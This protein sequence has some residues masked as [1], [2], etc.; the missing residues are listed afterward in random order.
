LIVSSKNIA[1][2]VQSTSVISLLDA[3]EG[4]IIITNILELFFKQNLQIIGEFYTS[5]QCFCQEHYWG[6]LHCNVNPW[7]CGVNFVRMTHGKKYLL[8]Y[9]L[10]KIVS[11]NTF[12][13]IFKTQSHLPSV[14]YV[15]EDIN[16]RI[17]T[18]YF[19]QPLPD[20]CRALGYSSR[21]S[22]SWLYVYGIS[23][24][25]FAGYGIWT[26]LPMRAH[27]LAESEIEELS[28]LSCISSTKHNF[29]PSANWSG[30]NK[31]IQ[32]NYTVISI[33]IN[34]RWNW[35]WH[36][37]HNFFPQCISISIST[38]TQNNCGIS[39]IVSL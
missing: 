25:V 1:N 26:R 38:Q 32:S 16:I 34:N 6:K 19:L 8:R 21:T 2:A 31:F 11:L 14:T 27:Q 18:W 23:V 5:T 3:L 33:S 24:G 20:V 9:N 30:H 4:S 39:I 28:T 37:L 15:N 36:Q 17:A 7:S 29:S 13:N 22:T 10:K 35:K 12:T